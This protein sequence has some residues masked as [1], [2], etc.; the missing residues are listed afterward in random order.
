MAHKSQPPNKNAV[1]EHLGLFYIPHFFTAC[2]R[3]FL[4]NAVHWKTV[5]CLELVLT[6]AASVLICEE[7]YGVA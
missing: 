3:A 1:A 4:P 5:W 7:L 2:P 6:S